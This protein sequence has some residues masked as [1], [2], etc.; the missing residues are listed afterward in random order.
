MSNTCPT[1]LMELIDQWSMGGCLSIGTPVERDRVETSPGEWETGPRP[2]PGPEPE[3]RNHDIMC[4][5]T[6]SPQTATGRQLPSTIMCGPVILSRMTCRSDW[7]RKLRGSTSRPTYCASL[8]QTPVGSAWTLDYQ[9]S[10]DCIWHV[11]GAI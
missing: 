11:V 6:C 3:D 8:Q 10:L 1:H 4:G 7:H 5:Q 9:W 2:E